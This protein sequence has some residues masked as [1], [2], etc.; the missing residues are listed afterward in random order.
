MRVEDDARKGELGHVGAANGDEPGGQQARHDGGMRAC[1]RRAGQHDRPGGGH[2]ASHIQQVLQ[3]HRDAGVGPGGAAILAQRV[4]CV[5]LGAGGFGHDGD[6]RPA[7]FARRVGDALEALF[8]EMTAGGAAGGQRLG[9]FGDC[10]HR[11]S[12]P[13]C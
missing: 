3:A 8:D 7:A 9:E 4:G 1:R 13:P 5:G 12:L 11:S 2:M 10:R 6:E